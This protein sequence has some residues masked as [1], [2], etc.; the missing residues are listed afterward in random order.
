MDTLRFYESIDAWVITPCA[1]GSQ[2]KYFEAIL[3]LPIL[4]IAYNNRSRR[5]HASDQGC[6]EASADCGEEITRF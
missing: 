4:L 3:H 2:K 6:E 5:T 1:N